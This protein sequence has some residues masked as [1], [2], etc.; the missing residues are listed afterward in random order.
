MSHEVAVGISGGGLH[1]IAILGFVSREEAEAW[2]RE[3]GFAHVRQG[4]WNCEGPA[5]LNLPGRGTVTDPKFQ[6]RI[7]ELLKATEITFKLA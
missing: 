4:V 5:T 1:D 3:H 6:A 7:D 2:L